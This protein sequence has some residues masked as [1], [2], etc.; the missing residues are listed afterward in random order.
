MIIKNRELNK[1]TLNLDASIEELIN[2][3]NENQ[4]KLSIIVN[5]KK[6]LIGTISDGDL[7]RGFLKGLKLN[8]KIKSII[9]YKPVTIQSKNFSEENAK[10]ILNTYRID[11]I[12]V[13]KNKNLLFIYSKKENKTKKSNNF[14]IVIMA[15]GFGKRL[16]KLT[17]LCPKPLLKF[18]NKALIQHIIDKSSSQGFSNFYISIYYLKQ[19]IKKYFKKNY[20]KKINVNFLEEKTPLGTIGS[21]RLVKKISKNF[22]V[23]NCDVISDINLNEVIQFHSKKKSL[24]TMC[25]KHFRYQNPYGVVKSQN[26]LFKAFEEKPSI[27]FKINA[28]IYIFSSKIIKYIKKYKFKNI[29]EL[30]NHLK[31][32]NEKISLFPIYENWLD[33]GSDYKNF[34]GNF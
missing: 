6:K 30:V 20:D 9:N 1:K 26:N 13:L 4:I 11:H 7:R 29:E 31:K 34:K 2:N 3:L 10:K 17:K 14:D 28:G 5:K 33:L 27:D 18:K 23:L 32:K 19:K 16:K 25:I 22:V 8:D 12:P 15:G 21:L 24:M